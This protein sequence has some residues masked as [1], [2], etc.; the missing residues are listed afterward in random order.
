LKSQAII[1][2]SDAEAKLRKYIDGA[3]QKYK[4]INELERNLKFIKNNNE[5]LRGDWQ[6]I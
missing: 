5:K 6:K 1:A 2:R 4:K 3:N